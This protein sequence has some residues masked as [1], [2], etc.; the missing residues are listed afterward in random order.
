MTMN[1]QE[2][3]TSW[4]HRKI[5]KATGRNLDDA[6][7]TFGDLWKAPGFPPQGLVLS[8]KSVVRSINLVMYTINISHGRPYVLPFDDHTSQLYYREKV[9]AKYLPNAVMD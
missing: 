4:L 3:L 2:T 1:K 8:E 7:L 6:L 9:L 5:Q